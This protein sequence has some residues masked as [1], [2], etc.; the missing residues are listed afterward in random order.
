MGNRAGGVKGPIERIFL[1]PLSL[2]APL[3]NRDLWKT[4]IVS[5]P[6]NSVGECVFS[7]LGETT[8]AR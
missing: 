7:A 3:A 5:T 6:T 8:N 4:R 1:T 2:C